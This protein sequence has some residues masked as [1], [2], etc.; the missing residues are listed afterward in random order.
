MNIECY[1]GRSF[2][3]SD[4]RGNSYIIFIW[5]YVYPCVG[6][7]YRYEI[8]CDSSTRLALQYNIAKLTV[9]TSVYKYKIDNT[10][11]NFCNLRLTATLIITT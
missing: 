1:I 4:A 6:T 7:Q 2:A 10:R 5:R 9:D 11:I 3:K 8:C